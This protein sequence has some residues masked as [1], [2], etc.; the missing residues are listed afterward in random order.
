MS[1]ESRSK[2]P[3][4]S[5]LPGEELVLPGTAIGGEVGTFYASFTLWNGQMQR[6]RAFNGLA[7]TGATFPQGPGSILEDMGIERSETVRFRMADGSST[8]LWLGHAL[9]EIEGSVRSVDVIF[10]PEGSSVL[11]GALALEAFGL[12]ADVSH[13]RLVPADVLQ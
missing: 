4:K 10:G 6:S 2:I 12:A 8:D 9:L 5:K 13:R 11:L 3:A 1:A 7:D